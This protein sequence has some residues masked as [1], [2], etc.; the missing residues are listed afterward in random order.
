[1]SY[2]TRILGTTTAM[3]MA[4]GATADLQYGEAILSA[5]SNCFTGTD[6]V[7]VRQQV[8]LFDSM[9][10]ASA[11]GGGETSAYLVA[12]A[13]WF[14]MSAGSTVP[15]Q[16]SQNDDEVVP[17]IIDGGNGAGAVEVEF[18]VD[19]PTL[20]R[21]SRCLEGS[22]V[23]FWD[24]DYQIAE[25][26]E[27]DQVTQLPSGDYWATIETD[28]YGTP[29]WAEIDW[30]Q[31]PEEFDPADV[32]GDGK[33][34]AA[35]LAALME[36]MPES[37]FQ[38]K[39]QDKTRNKTRSKTQDKPQDKT[40]DKPQAKPQE[41]PSTGGDCTDGAKS[42]SKGKSKGESK[43]TSKGNDKPAWLDG[44]K[45][46]P[47]PKPGS[48][49]ST[50]GEQ[51]GKFSKGDDQITNYDNQADGSA[52]SDNEIYGADQTGQSGPRFSNNGDL[53]ADGKVDIKDIVYLMGRL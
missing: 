36:L 6:H 10:A 45:P 41:K 52:S 7:L 24:G 11:C 14:V 30:H 2:T 1:M 3:I 51:K 49:G 21:M 50:K 20:F 23:I 46:M 48:F 8:N 13:E 31:Q 43:G 16:G 5:E 9:E 27:A 17:I 32:N 28:L 38:D 53:N 18:T 19:R 4:A 35:D 29:V 40:Q 34:N 22:K 15:G 44:A 12:D 33:V 47:K 37:K 25:L 42:K 39:T 26:N